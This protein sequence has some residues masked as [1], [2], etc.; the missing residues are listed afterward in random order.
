MVPLKDKRKRVFGLIG[1]DTLNDRHT[2]TI[3][4][5][6]EIQYFQVIEYD[7]K[8]AYGIGLH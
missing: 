3:F 1:V 8:I 6:H 4:I 2:K 5:T 7:V